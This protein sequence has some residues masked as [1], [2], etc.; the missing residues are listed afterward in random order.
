MASVDFCVQAATNYTDVDIL[1][2]ALNLE[3]LEAEYYSWAA[4][5]ESI[6][7]VDPALVGKLQQC[8]DRDSS[9]TPSGGTD[10]GGPSTPFAGSVIDIISEIAENEIA[11]VRLLRAV[12]GTRAVTCPA[13]SLTTETFTIAVTAAVD[14]LGGTVSP[15]TQT[16]NPYSSVQDFAVGAFIFEDVG[17]TAYK[18]AVQNLQNSTYAATAAG[19]MAIEAGH[20]AVIR[21]LM[22]AATGTDANTDLTYVTPGS[23]TVDPLTFTSAVTGINVLRDSLGG[24]SGAS[25]EQPLFRSVTDVGTYSATTG[26]ELFVADSTGD[27]YGRT[28]TQVLN[29]LYFDTT[30]KLVPGGFLPSGVSGNTTVTEITSSSTASK[31]CTTSGALSMAYFSA[32]SAAVLP[33]VIA[34]VL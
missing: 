6:Y 5:G 19:I 9:R 11:H 10:E 14:A 34:L 27:A 16:F 4:Y 29:I 17:V 12:L 25:V 26:L 18:G 2:F 7:S 31:N 33:A 23:A 30:M 22:A 20:A 28:P 21:Q 32:A 1:S 3:C 13:L 15:S 8:T 24:T